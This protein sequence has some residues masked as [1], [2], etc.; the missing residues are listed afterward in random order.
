[1]RVTLSAVWKIPLFCD[2]NNMKLTVVWYVQCGQIMQG[3]KRNMFMLT[4]QYEEKT[5]LVHFPKSLHQST[6]APSN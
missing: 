6:W 1:M 2:T 3:R 5:Y 4:I